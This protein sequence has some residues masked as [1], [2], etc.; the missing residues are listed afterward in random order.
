MSIPL[1]INGVTFNYP[2]QGDTNWG[3]TLTNWSSA[4]TSGMLQKAG[5]SFPLTAEVDF[6]GSFG[7]K[8][9]SI[10]SEESNIATAGYLRLANASTGINWR[11]ASNTSNLGLT[12]NAS[13]QLTFNGSPIGATTSLADNNFFIGNA[14]NVPTA[15]T[16]TGDVTTTNTGVVTIANSAITNV[17]VAAAAA[18]AVSKLAALTVSRAVATDTSGFLVASTT[19]AAELLFVNGVTSAIQTQLN[20][21]TAAQ[22]GFLPLAGGT[23]S[24]AIAMGSH[25]ITGL[26]Q[27]TTAADAI[28]FPVGTG[29]ISNLAIT[30]GLIAANAVTQNQSNGA[31]FP[32]ATNT[33]ITSQAITTTGGPVLIMAACTIAG[34]SGTVLG[35][36]QGACLIEVL[37][38]ATTITGA[39][40]YAQVRGLTPTNQIQS[41]NMHVVAVDAPTAGTYTYNFQY[42]NGNLGTETVNQY[43]LVLI[44]LKK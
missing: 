17:K 10:K 27:G 1:I 23:M 6:G 35:Q 43:S 8:V 33:L 18:I 40:A 26:T 31:S 7:M 19:T 21:L 30:T 25:K 14:G 13:D 20:A 44:E 9:L 32:N 36:I 12:V 28:A 38:G 4:V 39:N 2:Q 34:F 24:G 5:G 16:L 42:A 3:P 15:H 41:F 29:Q 11:N 37:R 22:A